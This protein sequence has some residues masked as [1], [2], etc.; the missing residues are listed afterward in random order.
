VD[1]AGRLDKVI[2]DRGW[3]YTWLD[4]GPYVFDERTECLA[5][6]SPVVLGGLGTGTPAGSLGEVIRNLAETA[7]EG[8]EVNAAEPDG[9]GVTIR[10][11]LL[12][13]RINVRCAYQ[14]CAGEI[15][16]FY[17]ASHVPGQVSGPEVIV[18]C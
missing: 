14:E 13:A 18:W 17:S 2:V 12:G 3:R 8:S 7:G 10:R 16:A 6:I 15:A 1:E 9:E 11:R 4:N 5:R